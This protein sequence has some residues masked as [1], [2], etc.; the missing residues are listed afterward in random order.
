MDGNA[1]VAW[2]SVPG[3]GLM[4]DKYPVPRAFAEMDEMISV[5]KLKNHAFMGITL[6]MKN[7]FGLMPTEPAGPTAHVLSSSGAHALYAG[8]FGAAV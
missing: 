8:R 4:F 5:Q 2:A 7:L 1:D 6:C 3:G